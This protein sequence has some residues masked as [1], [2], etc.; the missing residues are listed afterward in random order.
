[1]SAIPVTIHYGTPPDIDQQHR[2]GK[3]CYGHPGEGFD[4]SNDLN[5]TGL[6]WRSGYSSDN[7]GAQKYYIVSRAN[8]EGIGG[9]PTIPTYH[10]TGKTDAEILHLINRLHSI[11]VD[12]SFYIDP[13]GAKR[14]VI[15]N[16]NLNHFFADLSNYKYWSSPNLRLNFDFGNLNCD[17]LEDNLEICYDLCQTIDGA[18]ERRFN[19]S[20]GT[21]ETS[22][23]NAANYATAN[24]RFNSPSD[25]ITLSS[26]DINPNIY[27]TPL[28]TQSGQSFMFAMRCRFTQSPGQAV[29]LMYTNGG[30]TRLRYEDSTGELLFV[31]NAD[32]VGITMQQNTWVTIIFGRDG[33]GNLFIKDDSNENFTAQNGNTEMIFDNGF[34]L[35]TYGN[36]G[37]LKLGSFQYWKGAN[38]DSNKWNAVND[39]QMLSRWS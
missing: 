1:M 34:Y 24:R 27:L 20:G 3:Y 7:F 22:F 5:T 36:L 8:V 31:M 14:Y 32:S 25:Y 37:E 35:G 38:Y 21:I 19:N 15:E 10:V 39:Y 18:I 4:F 12:G 23:T 30:L 33:S 16:E 29:N 11:K 17:V 13:I 6:V 28:N 26:N 9:E 2:I